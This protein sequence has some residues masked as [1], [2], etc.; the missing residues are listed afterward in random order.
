[1]PLATHHKM[2]QEQGEWFDIA[3]RE[4]EEALRRLQRSQEKDRER[5]LELKEQERAVR[6]HEREQEKQRFLD[7]R[8]QERVVEE[9]ER[10]AFL[11]VDAVHIEASQRCQSLDEELQDAQTALVSTEASAAAVEEQR[12]A[13]AASLEA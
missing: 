12:S 10:A 1:M 4:L 9:R 6:E 7:A 3:V 13:L 5:L 11:E 8:E 2:L